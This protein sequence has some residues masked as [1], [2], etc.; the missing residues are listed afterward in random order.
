MQSAV[1]KFTD[2]N[3]QIVENVRSVDFEPMFVI[4]YRE[5]DTVVAFR[6]EL[7]LEAYTTHDS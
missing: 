7:V 3:I 6:S 2:A 1:I 4:I 5:D